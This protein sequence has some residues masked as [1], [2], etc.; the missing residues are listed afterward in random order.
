VLL[1]INV[2]VHRAERCY[3]RRIWR[4]YGPTHDNHARCTLWLRRDVYCATML[5]VLSSLDHA[6][7][8]VRVRV[9]RALRA[10][11]PPGGS[12]VGGSDE[13]GLDAANARVRLNSASCDQCKRFRFARKR[14]TTRGLENLDT[15]SGEFCLT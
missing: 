13:T 6:T 8:V 10:P 1:G 11:L 12:A 3:F 2:R 7:G 4:I 9:F 5:A 14:F 15:I